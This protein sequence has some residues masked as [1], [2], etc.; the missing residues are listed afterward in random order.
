MEQNK[1]YIL[2]SKLHII[3]MGDCVNVILIIINHTNTKFSILEFDT[4]MFLVF[5]LSYISYTGHITGIEYR[6]LVNL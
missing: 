1:V 6:L 2:H 4:L 3:L 5:G